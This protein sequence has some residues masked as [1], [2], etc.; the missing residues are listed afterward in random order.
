MVPAYDE[1][2]G[3]GASLA[4]VLLALQKVEG[5]SELVV[6]DDGSTDRTREIAEGSGARVISLPENR[7]YGAAILAGIAAAK[8]DT[9]VITDADGTYPAGAI[10]ELLKYRDDYEMVVGARVGPNDSLAV[11]RVAST[12][13]PC[14]RC[15]GAAR[16]GRAPCRDRR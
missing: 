12:G 5:E 11:H 7:G 1:E 2:E 15:N 3:I 13:R 16:P 8:Y 10:P 6:V 14:R 9:I 4:D